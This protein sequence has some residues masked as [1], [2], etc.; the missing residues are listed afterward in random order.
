MAKKTKTVKSCMI[1][2]SK[3]EKLFLTIRRL[4]VMNIG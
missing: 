3:A 4:Q 1:S 2:A